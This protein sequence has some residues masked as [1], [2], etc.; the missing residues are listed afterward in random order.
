MRALR[1]K[2]K[3]VSPAE[4]V[5]ALNKYLARSEAQ[6]TAKDE[7]KMTDEDVAKNNAKISENLAAM[8]FMLYGD[9]D[10]E[11]KDENRKKLTNELCKGGLIKIILMLRTFD[12]EGKKD[13][14]A[15]A[16]HVIRR[17]E[18]NGSKEIIAANLKSI[19]DS[20]IL[21]YESTEGALPAGSILQEIAK[22]KYFVQKLLEEPAEK[23]LIFKVM[24]YVE[25]RN[26]D[27]A[28]DAFTTLKLLTTRHK[29]VLVKWLEA[30]YSL[31]FRLFNGLINSENYVSRRQS[32]RLLGEILLERKNFT[33]MMKYIE[34]RD[35]L[36]LMMNMLKN[37][38][39]AIQFEAF[40]VFKVFVANPKQTY[41][42][43]LV[44]WNNKKRLI[45]YL[46]KFQKDRE[47]PQFI[48]EK[49]LVIKHLEQITRPVEPADVAKKARSSVDN[50]KPSKGGGGGGG[51]QPP[52]PSK[53]RTE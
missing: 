30:N 36:K 7:E 53:S 21:G 8:K 1:K 24:N 48:S 51:D 40:H 41:P 4:L 5:T 42:I 46:K 15:V 6:Y 17:S 27:V 23:T 33:I 26:F 52:A 12:F 50:G 49:E 47:D 32:L 22:Q 37:N 28:S 31:F 45:D 19:T 9:A 44:L 18:N 39:N 29:D 11:P 3:G 10:N 35:N 13:A 34:D 43:K 20:L 2:L 38:S 14:A 16:N 25:K